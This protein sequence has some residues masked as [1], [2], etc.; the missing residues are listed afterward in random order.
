MKKSVCVI[1]FL[2]VSFAS[3]GAG[4]K[5]IL[6]PEI[7]LYQPAV[8]NAPQ[9]TMNME[10][11][12]ITVETQKSTSISADKVLAFYRK[13]MKQLGWRII[14]PAGGSTSWTLS[15]YKGTSACLIYFTANKDY[16][17]DAP[18]D[19]LGARIKIEYWKDCPKILQQN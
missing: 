8:W 2:L 9:K 18:A 4:N 13:K 7:P 16:A 14:G 1:L 5:G 15:C 3:A 11:P 12:C 17:T 10:K 19:P 6:P